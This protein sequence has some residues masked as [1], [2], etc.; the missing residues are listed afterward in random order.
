MSEQIAMMM[1]MLGGLALGLVTF[2]IGKSA[3]YSEGWK[4]G[5]E[6]SIKLEDALGRKEE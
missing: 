5:I 2:I 1:W 3:G 4:N 6:D